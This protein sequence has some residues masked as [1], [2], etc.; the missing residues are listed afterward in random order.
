MELAVP[1]LDQNDDRPSPSANPIVLGEVSGSVLLPES[2]YF[3]DW[4]S[5]VILVLL[6]VV[7]YHLWAFYP[8][9]RGY[10]MQLRSAIRSRNFNVD[11]DVSLTV[12]TSQPPQVV[13]VCLTPH[14]HREITPT[15]QGINEIQVES[16]Q[17]VIDGDT[18]SDCH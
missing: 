18:Y 15:I 5:W 11:M 13:R 1:Y 3:W 17:I 10:W 8:L 9:Y 6:V 7:G 2:S 14:S 12:Q 4:H 16:T